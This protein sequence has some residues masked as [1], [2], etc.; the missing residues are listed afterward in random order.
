[1]NKSEY[2]GLSS[3][4]QVA[5]IV[6]DEV[7]KEKGLLIDGEVYIDYTTV[8]NYLNSGYYWEASDSRLLL[9]LP[10]E[11]NIWTPKDGSDAVILD[12]NG[13]PYISATC[14]RKNSDIDM[15]ILKE[16]YRVVARTY[17]NGVIV[18]T[19]TEDSELRYREWCNSEILTEVK[20][21]DTM[22]L[23][24]DL[25]NCC[26]VST[27]DGYIGYVPKGSFMQN[28]DATLSHIT[29]A[30]FQFQKISMDYKISLGWHY[31][32]SQEGKE[33]LSERISEAAG[34]NT[35]SPTWFSLADEQGNLLS[36]ADKA[37]V[38]QAHAAGL[39][40][41]GMLDD[42]NKSSIRTGEVLAGAS[43]RANI[44]QQLLQIAADSHMDGINVDFEFIKE[45][46]APQYLQ[47]LKELCIAAHAQNLVV[48]TNNFV[49]IYT[50]Y[51][52]RAEQA[53]T[54]DYLII[55]GYDEHTASSKKIGSVAS[56]PFVEQGIQD[57]LKEVSAEQVINAIPFYT[58]SWVETIDTSMTKSKVLDMDAA[59][60][61]V[62][63]H[64]IVTTWDASV[65]Q[66]V[67]SVEEES[68]RYSIWLEDEQSV[69]AKMK[70]ITRY[71]LAGVAG[72]RLGLERASVWN[73][74]AQYLAA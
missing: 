41:W 3:K 64:G 61:F 2:Y 72:W 44:V 65:G 68:V 26:R 66:K 60:A 38:E 59:A 14:I 32:N 67:G 4:T 27:T 51:Y 40:V 20:K 37:Y 15:N 25:Q 18:G 1:M 42:V 47:F 6:N 22:V 35:I 45:D 12:E 16:P 73:I 56:L 57:T 10:A 19:M 58:R 11:T 23:L 17:W 7:L 31:V 5:L 54:V 30:R 8:W 29:D 24:E 39:Q 69:E 74:I 70:L 21:G 52:K 55:M 9:T 48:S 34:L 43:A 36:Y 49:P 46:S 50:E 53:K 13:V 33:S 63:R 62:E 71:N 28:N